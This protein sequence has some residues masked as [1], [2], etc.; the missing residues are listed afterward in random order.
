[1]LA[2]RKPGDTVQITFIRPPGETKTV[3]VTLAELPA[4]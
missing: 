2:T 1:V 3:T 4:S